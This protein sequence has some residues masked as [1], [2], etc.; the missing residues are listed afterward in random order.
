MKG[1][2]QPANEEV[3]VFVIEGVSEIT[4]DNGVALFWM[5][6]GTTAKVLAAVRMEP[7][8]LVSMGESPPRRDSQ[9]T[10]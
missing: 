7:G 3:P 2:I 6:Q 10:K 5:G 9:R 4:L 1:F 8:L